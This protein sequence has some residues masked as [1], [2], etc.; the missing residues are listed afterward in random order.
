MIKILSKI[1]KYSLIITSIFILITLSIILLFYLFLDQYNKKIALS[2]SSW[3]TAGSVVSK[4]RPWHTS[5]ES[6]DQRYKI[7]FKFVAGE[8]G[9]KKG[10]ALKIS[11]GHILPTARKIYTP[12]SLTVPSVFFFDI[13]LLKDVKAF[14]N[15]K[16]ITLEIDEPST[17]KSLLDI[18]SLIKYKRSDS[19]KKTRDN[20]LRQIDNEFAIFIKITEGSLKKDDYIDIVIGHEDGFAAPKRDAEWEIIVRLDGD[21]DG[22][23]G[24]ITKTS[25][26]QVYSP[27]TKKVVLTAPS[28]LYPGETNSLVI[29][30]EDDH[31]LP[32]LTRFT[33]ARI[34]LYKL[35]GL[36]FQN[37]IE[38]K[39]N[40][41]DRKSC[42]IEIPIKAIS[43]GL[44]RIK[45]EAFIDDKRYNILSNPIEVIPTG[46]KKIFFGDTHL[47][48][49]ISYDADRPP[50]Y[51]Y[52]RQKFAERHDFAFLSDHDMIGAI[53]FT[54]R[55]SVLGRSED[56]WDYIRELTDKYYT[57]GKFVTLYAYEWTSYYY[58]HRNIYFSPISAD[59]PLF[60]HNSISESEPLDEKSPGELMEQLSSSQDIDYIAIPHSTAW[61][62]S[63]VF[64]HWGPGEPDKWPQQRLLELY[65]THGTSEYH[66]NEYAVDKGHREIPTES[67]IVKKLMNYD[68]RQAPK[69]SGNFARDALR[70][71]WRFGFIGSSDKHFL[72]HIDQAY[73]YGLAAAYAKKLSRKELWKSLVRRET[74]AVTGVRMLI[75]FSA[76]G[77]PMGSENCI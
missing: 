58:G 28:N 53:P 9:I 76:N 47:H 29:R 44:Y 1:L 20:L 17:L 2:N 14:P 13:N 45:G 12:F 65:S 22:K 25:S 11:L 39:G 59:P 50:D 35:D 69:D 48:S 37:Q 3:D 34:I 73:K 54:K 68:I 70:A 18:I 75:E 57:P 49:I 61:P 63:G 23:Y 66:N 64:Y 24:L 40:V 26:F 19:G 38:V 15:K 10:G 74:Y 4:T 16:N 6:H 52:W 30:T 55:T 27:V 33:D 5:R 60:R 72:S 8:P 51:V 71:G 67:T 56:E 36:K 62:T 32:N 77:F 42:I 21:G 31:F 43:K 46:R 7:S 41:N